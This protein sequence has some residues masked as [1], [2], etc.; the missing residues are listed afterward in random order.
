MPR[1]VSRP[2]LTWRA[3]WTPT[4]PGL[5]KLLFS[6]YLQQV[7]QISVPNPDEG[8]PN[9]VSFGSGLLSHPDT[10]YSVWPGSV[11]GYFLPHRLG[12]APC[13]PKKQDKRYHV[14]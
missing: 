5:Q 7:T 11:S 6:Q 14:T 13:E 2:S 3:A 12:I 4:R 9:L 10:R 8:M 1:R